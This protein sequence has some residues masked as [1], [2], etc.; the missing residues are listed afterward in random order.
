MK[1][2]WEGA[3]SQGLVCLAAS[4]QQEEDAQFLTS[5]DS[6]GRAVSRV[7][8]GSLGSDRPGLRVKGEMVCGLL[9][10]VGKAPYT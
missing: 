10:L 5:C 3:R 6:R 1:I 7:N 2:D 4:G 9:Q 8:W